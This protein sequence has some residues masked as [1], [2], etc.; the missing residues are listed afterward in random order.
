MSV[1]AVSFGINYANHNGEEKDGESEE[2]GL[3]FV[4]KVCA[5]AVVEVGSSIKTVSVAID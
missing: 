3:H 1:F 5:G 2:K 4:V